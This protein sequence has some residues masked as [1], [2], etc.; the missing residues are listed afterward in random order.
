MRGLYFSFLVLVVAG[1]GCTHAPY[2]TR[3]PGKVPLHAPLDCCV[4]DLRR[5]TRAHA[6]DDVSDEGVGRESRYLKPQIDHNI[7]SQAP[8]STQPA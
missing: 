3:D 2:S 1:T 5:H 7:G 8:I 6:A 4:A